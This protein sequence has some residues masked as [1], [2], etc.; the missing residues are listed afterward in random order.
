MHGS[1]QASAT[2]AEDN[3]AGSLEGKDCSTAG[4]E[5]SG[6]SHLP[7]SEITTTTEPSEQASDGREVGGEKDSTEEHVAAQEDSPPEPP[8]SVLSEPAK[9]SIILIASFAAIISPISSSIYFPALNSLAQDLDVSVSL[10]TLTVTTYL[11]G[12]DIIIHVQ[13]PFYRTT[14][15]PILIIY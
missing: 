4:V 7:E 3:A 1:V 14:H 13:A 11:V 12:Q 8:Y 5:L 10:I 2:K 9:V 6:R 15:P